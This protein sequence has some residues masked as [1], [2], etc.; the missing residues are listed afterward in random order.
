[1]SLQ[2]HLDNRNIWQI[3]T[4]EK[5][6]QQL[7]NSKIHEI[8]MNRSEKVV[9]IY[10]RPQIG[11][12]TLILN[13]L[14]ISD[15]Y[16][17]IVYN[18]IRAGI[19]K[20]NSSTSTSTLYRQSQSDNYSIKFD[21]ISSLDL[22]TKA[23]SKEEFIKEIQNIRQKVENNELDDGV[24]HIYIPKK[25]FSE[26]SIEH[27]NISILDLPGDGSNNKNEHIHV[28]REI[29]KYLDLASCIII[30]CPADE[31]QSLENLEDKNRIDKSWK[32]QK[33]RYILVITVAYTQGSVKSY[34]R[35]ALS[36][37]SKTFLEF[38]SENYKE[39][40]NKVLPMID[41]EY[42]PIDIGDSLD[43][44]LK[45]ELN[46][47]K[48]KKEVNDTVNKFL[49]DI[50]NAIQSKKGN[51]LK[52]CIEQLKIGIKNDLEDMKIE[53]ERQTQDLEKEIIKNN[54]K[55][56]KIEREIEIIKEKIDNEKNFY[57]EYIKLRTA[58]VSVSYISFYNKVKEN[59][60][61]EYSHKN[62]GKI[63]KKKTDN[64]IEDCEK[65]LKY[66]TKKYISSYEK[67]LCSFKDNSLIKY[68]CN[69]SS[70]INDKCI[71]KI[72]NEIDNDNQ[73]IAKIKKN[74]EI[75][76]LINLFKKKSVWEVNDIIENEFK[77]YSEK[78]KKIVRTDQE[79]V[80]E[81]YRTQFV[82]YQKSLT[83]YNN[84]EKEKDKI[85]IKIQE[86]KINI[87]EYNNKIATV[88]E[89]IREENKKLSNYLEVAKKEYTKHKNFIMKKIDDKNTNLNDRIEFLIYLGLIEMDYN[90]VS[91]I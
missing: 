65:Q 44:L 3:N 67:E 23:F 11:K 77:T 5:I 82:T 78:L 25:Y 89:N 62:S 6:K 90:Q 49:I 17:D 70:D 52:S 46:D 18:D 16:I 45:N 59:I 91:E 55:M 7:L 85:P 32:E 31:I 8:N 40:I 34:F 24:L 68:K 58:R 35:K 87:E 2:E 10:G 84:H 76:G 50:R 79:L 66:F 73:T 30:A 41:I 57:D 4:I 47:D 26:D 53:Y 71:D 88:E 54:N 33:N 14:G 38:I 37:R 21:K 43:S 13:L 61:T 81:K 15:K 9:A 80:L 1:M 51:T 56:N 75:T 42:F 86:I 36:E 69:I 28:D 22:D 60:E 27:S 74:I 63:D 12:T 72:F 29:K 39:Q 48:D 20:G 19:I 83:V 64:I